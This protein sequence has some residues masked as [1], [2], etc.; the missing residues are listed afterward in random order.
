ML[1]AD[2]RPRK[3]ASSSASYEIRIAHSESRVGFDVSLSGS[4]EEY[5]HLVYKNFSEEHIACILRVEQE[6]E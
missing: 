3:P 5:C 4:Y 2:P 1:F 6:T